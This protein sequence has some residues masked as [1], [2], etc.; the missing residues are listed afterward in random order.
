[1]EEG[2]SKSTE[3]S[4]RRELTLGFTHTWGLDGHHLGPLAG[5]MILM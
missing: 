1:M 3:A 2:N 5:G 4:S